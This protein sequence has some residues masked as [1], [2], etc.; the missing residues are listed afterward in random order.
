MHYF[1]FKKTDNGAYL[2]WSKWSP[3]SQSC[4][5][6]KRS[7]SR[8]HT[9]LPGLDVQTETCGSVGGYSHWLVILIKYK[10]K[11]KFFRAPA[12]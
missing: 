7:R 4:Y 10:S 9:C 3:C 8:A 12:P 2:H 6:G 1:L 11:S 5:G